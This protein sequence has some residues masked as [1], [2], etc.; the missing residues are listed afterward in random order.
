MEY[1]L[2]SMKGVWRYKNLIHPTIE[3]S[4][5]VTKMEGNTNL[6]ENFRISDFTG[7]KNIHLKHEGENP[8]GSF[9]DRGMTVAISEAKRLK[10]NKTLCASTGNTSA[11]AASYSS[12]AG[13]E[14]YVMIPEKNVSPNKLF[15]AIAYGANIVNIDGDFDNAMADV[16]ETISKRNDFY[17]LNSLNP[18]RIEGQKTII[19]EIMEDLEPDFI[20]FPAGNLGNTSAF[21]KALMELKEMGRINKIPRLVA[22]QA[23]GAAPFYNY[24]NNK[25]EVMIPV[26]A[27]TIATAIKIGSPVNFKKAKRSIEFT[28]GIVEK[29]SDEEI[30]SSKRIIDRSGIGCEPAS[31]ASVAGIKK[32]RERGIIDRSDIVVSILTG[33]ILKD[34][35]IVPEHKELKLS[36]IF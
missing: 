24:I 13:L 6:Y 12:F 10:F 19:Y 5:I 29:V 16:K 22:I 23:N 17:L 28:S 21:G 35:S 8:T 20:S 3:N 18:W 1:S 7:I 32:L 27:E 14:S 11:A 9:K 33:N 26:K 25:S 4:D 2:T 34:V 36:D 31:A 15:Q 30:L